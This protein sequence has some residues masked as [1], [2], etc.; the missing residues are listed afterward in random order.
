MELE[1]R[2][3]PPLSA[4]FHREERYKS[5]NLQTGSGRKSKHSPQYDQTPT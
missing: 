4:N 3:R 2:Q 5:R 1:E